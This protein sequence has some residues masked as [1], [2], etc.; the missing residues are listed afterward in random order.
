MCI[1]D[2]VL[3]D[4]VDAVVDPTTWEVPRIFRE[5]QAMGGV[6]DDEMARVFNMGVGMV[7]AVPASG[8]DDVVATLATHDRSAW[9][10]GE[11]VP[12]SGTMTYREVTGA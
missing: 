10:V 9:V 5:L 7:L 3:G 11:L 12:G 8:V 2:R 6:D 1:R 4:A